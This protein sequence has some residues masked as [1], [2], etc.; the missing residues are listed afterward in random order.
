MI[1]RL[2][3]AIDF[4]E[5]FTAD[6]GMW[7]EVIKVFQKYQHKVVCVTFR[8]ESEANIREVTYALPD[9]VKAYFTGGVQK[10]KFMDGKEQINI[11]IDDLPEAIPRMEDMNQ[12][13]NFGAL[14]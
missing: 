9:G 4:D 1:P 11:W 14:Y 5:T 7:V 13:V 10:K 6:V 12:I 2:T 3:I 8:D